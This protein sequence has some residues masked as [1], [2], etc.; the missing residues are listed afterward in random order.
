MV[1]EVK[2][3]VQDTICDRSLPCTSSA[4]YHVPPSVIIVFNPHKNP[5]SQ[6]QLM[7]FSHLTETQELYMTCLE[8]SI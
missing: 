7:L 6:T 2:H 4:N 1:L 5:V 3:L 8:A